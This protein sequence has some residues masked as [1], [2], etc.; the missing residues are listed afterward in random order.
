MNGISGLGK[1]LVVIGL[2]LIGLGAILWLS[3]KVPGIGR[4]PGDI[5]IR[6]ENFTFY[7]PVA[8]CIILS[9]LLTIILALF[10]RH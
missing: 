8:T 4:L 7:F 9:I 6:K 1:M 3:G 5:V 10:R 2:I